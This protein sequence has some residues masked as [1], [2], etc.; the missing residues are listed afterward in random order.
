MILEMFWLYILAQYVITP[1]NSLMSRH[2]QDCTQDC[3]IAL[4][5]A[6]KPSFQEL[7]SSCITQQHHS[8]SYSQ[9]SLSILS[10]RRCQGL[11]RLGWLSFARLSIL[12]ILIAPSRKEQECH[13]SPVKG[14]LPQGPQQLVTCII[15]TPK[16]CLQYVVCTDNTQNGLNWPF[17]PLQ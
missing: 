13:D 9:G 11:S 8:F 16:T 17:G 5:Q 14:S 6:S 3:T 2:A 10:Q 1:L 15:C 12:V 7:I 4:G